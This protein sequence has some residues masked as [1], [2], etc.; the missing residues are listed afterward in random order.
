[1]LTINPSE[2][3]IPDLQRWLQS[4]IG[5]RPIAFVSTI[6][7]DGTPN[8]A[9][10]SFYNVFSTNPPVIGFSPARR[11]RNN[12]L[13]DTYNNLMNNGECVVHSVNFN[14]VE[15]V[16]L[17][18]SE[19]LAEQNEFSIAGFTPLNSDLVKPFRVKESPFQME[20]KLLQMIS[21]SDLPGAGNLALCQVL[22]IH[23][24]DSILD[25]G[26]IHPDLIDLVGRNGGNWYTRSS[27]SAM[28]E[29]EKPA[30]SNPIGFD[31][32][33]EQILNSNVLSA[34][35]LARIAS[36]DKFPETIEIQEFLS[37]FDTSN[38]SLESFYRYYDVLD[39][40]KMLNFALAIYQHN[41]DKGFYLLELTLK[42]A[43]DMGDINFGMNLAGFI[44]LS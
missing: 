10:F 32:L 17:A 11:G 5:P 25:D 41:I 14:M 20:C 7:D 8:L 6:S 31:K 3:K 33:P 36:A 34:N 2:L 15:K 18:S 16:N 1:M 4:G 39:Y 28:F 35:N 13:K 21:F 44:Y 26:K 23:I 19:L 22:K 27:G 12:T 37:L 30:H 9:P 29:L 43:L 24:D 42:T 38:D 40:Y